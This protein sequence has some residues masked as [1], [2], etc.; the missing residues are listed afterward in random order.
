MLVIFQ[1]FPF[2]IFKFLGASPSK[3]LVSLEIYSCRSALAKVFSPKNKNCLENVML[4]Y[5]EREKLPVKYF[6]ALKHFVLSTELKSL[7]SLANQVKFH[8]PLVTQSCGLTFDIGQPLKF[9][10]EELFIY[11]EIVFPYRI[12]YFTYENILRIN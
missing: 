11:P 7:W 4:Q 6:V 5:R 10:R 12:K 8:F 3:V 2:C 1:I 9:K